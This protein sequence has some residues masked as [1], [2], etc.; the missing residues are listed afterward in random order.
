[1]KQ[2]VEEEDHRSRQ[3]PALGRLVDGL[4]DVTGNAEARDVGEVAADG[5]PIL[6]V[7]GEQSGIDLPYRWRGQAVGDRSRIA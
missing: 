5:V 3:T 1:L 4:H 7:A 2:A 6:V